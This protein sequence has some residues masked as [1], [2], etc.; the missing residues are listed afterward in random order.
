M[1][2]FANL[3]AHNIRDL[4]IPPST[5]IDLSHNQLSSLSG[6]P[7]PHI[8]KNLIVSNN[9]FEKFEEEYLQQCV[10]INIL[11][12][13][14]NQIKKIENLFY[15][16]H[17]HSLNLS[18]NE[19]SVVENLE[20][21]VNLRQLFLSENRI[22]TIFIR[23][24][25]PKLIFLDLSGNKLRRLTGINSFPCLSTLVIERCLL[26][27]LNGLQQLLNL[28]RISAAS[29]Q[30][31]DFLPFPLPLLSH[32]DLRNNNI[33]SIS[34]FTQFQ[35]LVLLDLSGNPIDDNGLGVDA[36]FPELKEF[37]ANG[38][39]IS[40][41][42]FIATIAPNVVVVSLLFCK[43]SSL[44]NV[45]LLTS[46]AKQLTYLDLRGNPINAQCYPDTFGK[47]YDDPLPEY[48]SEDLYDHQ[49][50]ESAPLRQKYRKAIISDAKSE[51]AYL[52]G[53]KLPWKGSISILPPSQVNFQF[54]DSLLDKINE[55][56]SDIEQNVQQSVQCDI[57]DSYQHPNVALCNIGMQTEKRIKY[58]N[59]QYPP[60]R[61][62]FATDSSSQA[63]SIIDDNNNDN[64]INPN[65]D[66]Y[67]NKPQP[68]NIQYYENSDNE[69]NDQESSEDIPQ[70]Q[71]EPGV[72]RMDSVSNSSD[73]GPFGI[74]LNKMGVNC[75]NTH[76]DNDFS[77]DFA[78]CSAATDLES[79]IFNI[80]DSHHFRPK[81][82][83]QGCFVHKDS[84][85]Q[86]VQKKRGGCAFWVDI[87]P[88]KRPKKT[89]KTPKQRAQQLYGDF[90]QKTYST[91]GQYPFN[92]KS[93]RRLPWDTEPEKPLSPH[94][95]PRRL[96]KKAKKT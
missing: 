15:L 77:D 49:Y 35:S 79:E 28:R 94:R 1:S 74:D 33:T 2:F 34:S 26:T 5:I 75:I 84:Y 80:S 3:N 78:N 83:K 30:I 20:G 76:F 93:A 64:N 23:S 87:Q 57:S 59:D 13:S 91:R 25:L 90:S 82:G 65:N 61:K 46:S 95:K 44:N 7:S 54:E 69:Y 96:Y 92:T 29:N 68:P 24:P 38:T 85:G 18:H 86:E 52:D 16:H 81:S 37:R 12:F 11:D 32:V 71:N 21:D 31:S 36:E 50:P 6:L 72:Y 48:D 4:R 14:F 66:L 56:Q 55:S 88:E 43:I 62:I 58:K 45:Q 19:I 41:P 40:D 42:S 60:Q 51:L 89:K 17:L 27:T 73:S 39:N 47:V 9:N 8:I 70:M 53:V 67:N 10:S 22:S 63:E